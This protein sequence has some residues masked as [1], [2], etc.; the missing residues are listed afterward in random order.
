MKRSGRVM[1]RQ[2]RGSRP[3]RWRAATLAA[4]LE[5][6][7]SSAELWTTASR[8][9]RALALP[10]AETTAFTRDCKSAGTVDRQPLSHYPAM[11]DST[12][13]CAVNALTATMALGARAQLLV[14][15]CSP[16]RGR[17]ASGFLAK[18]AVELRIAAKAGFEGRR[19]RRRGSAAAVKEHEALESLLV[20]KPGDRYACLRLEEPAQVGGAEAARDGRGWVGRRR[21]GRREAGERRPPLPD[22]RRRPR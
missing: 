7:A 3:R 15:G 10:L 1:P 9:Q 21:R 13:A 14:N 11:A 20:A 8:P 5:A 2:A 4:P 12:V 6:G 16:Q 22:G 18:H 19:E 17:V